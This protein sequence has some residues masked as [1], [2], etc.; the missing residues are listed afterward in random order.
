M[1]TK[2]L[3]SF[4]SLALSN[5]NTIVSSRSIDEVILVNTS[6]G[7]NSL[8]STQRSAIS[9]AKTNLPT[10]TSFSFAF[11]NES[12]ASLNDDFYNFL[13]SNSFTFFND[14]SLQSLSSSLVLEDAAVTGSSINSNGL[15]SFNSTDISENNLYTASG[16][17]IWVL[18]LEISLK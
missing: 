7:F 16:T 2:L 11:A 10:N 6:T 8:S 13:S 9:T 14:S 5:L 3:I 17:W 1:G 15:S 4:D 12:S 18:L